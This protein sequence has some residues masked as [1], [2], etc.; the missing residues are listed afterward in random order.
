[1]RA[2]PV[3]VPPRPLESRPG[4]A[5]G[6]ARVGRSRERGTRGCSPR[7][8]PVTPAPMHQKL[9]TLHLLVASFFLPTALMFAVTGG[10]YTVAIKGSY[11]ESKH[12]VALERPLERELGALVT[13]AS[14]ELG[15][16]GLSAPSGSASLRRAGTSFEL[17]W[18]GAARDVVLR[19]TGDSLRAELVVKDTTAWRHLVQLHK[20]K[21]SALARGFSVA[22]SLG[23]VV[24]LGSGMALGLN[25]RAY[26]RRALLAAGAGTAAFVA[27][28]VTG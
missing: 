11:R 14:A 28:A 5:A 19:P 21:G 1:M 7:R 10:L 3:N 2:H 24:V 22:W 9:V 27:Y 20:A 15:A 4:R 25:A 12:E 23:L 8:A 18:T 13:L 17:E 6:A 16:R 26:R